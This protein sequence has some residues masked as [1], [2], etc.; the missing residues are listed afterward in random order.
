MIAAIN[1]LPDHY[2]EPVVLCDMQ[3]FQYEEI[4]SMLDINLG[5]VKS[6]ISRGREELRKKL[7]DI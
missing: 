3:G 5:T 2:R 7:K 1:E 4:A 6:R